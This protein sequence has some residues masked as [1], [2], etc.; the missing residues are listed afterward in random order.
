MGDHVVSEE[1]SREGATSAENDNSAAASETAGAAAMAPGTLGE[2][3]ASPTALDTSFEAEGEEAGAE[4]PAVV[5]SMGPTPFD[6]PT[7]HD[8]GHSFFF[9]PA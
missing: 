8:G 3:E 4:M 9:G 1:A 7:G 6:N 5:V 2:G